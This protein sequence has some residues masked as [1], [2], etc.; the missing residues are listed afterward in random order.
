MT[1]QKA[2]TPL[3]GAE[4]NVGMLHFLNQWL[5]EMVIKACSTPQ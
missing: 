5:R 4:K 1:E 3:E 2:M